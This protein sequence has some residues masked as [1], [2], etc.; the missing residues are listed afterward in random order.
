M[1]FNKGKYMKK[2]ME[3]QTRD[4]SA[5]IFG[6]GIIIITCVWLSGCGTGP[7]GA[8]GANGT[9]GV[10]G[11]GQA[12]PMGATGVQGATG[13]TG[14][15]ATSAP[16][17][18][19]QQLVDAENRYREGLGQTYLTPGLSCNVQLVGSGSWLSAGSPGYVAAQGVVTALAGST[20]Y[21][22]LFQNSFDQP[23]SST[24]VNRL[25]P[26]AI[27]NVFVNNNYKISCS[28]QY[29]VT[30]TDY[31]NFDMNSDDGSILTVDG[32]QVINDDGT[33][34]MTDKTGTKYLRAGVHTFGLLYAQSGLGNFGLVLQVN[35]SLVTPDAW[36]H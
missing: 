8:S 36:Y 17:S 35:G 28:G 9:N 23:D 2:S 13:A 7:M 30:T 20:N 5:I 19:L 27:Q 16:E 32:T 18:D 14:P 22:Y 12:G 29:V 24:G 6:F 10:D 3:Q 1:N 26:L 11:V 4:W 21:T 33:H 34:A 15:T 25:I 31:Y